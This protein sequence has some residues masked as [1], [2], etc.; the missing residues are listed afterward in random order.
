MS[1]MY[2]IIARVWTCP[3]LHTQEIFNCTLTLSSLQLKVCRFW[4]VLGALVF[5]T[6]RSRY[7]LQQFYYTHVIIAFTDGFWIQEYANWPAG[8]I[9]FERS[10]TSF[11]SLSHWK[12]SGSKDY[13]VLKIPQINRTTLKK[14]QRYYST[15]KK[16]TQETNRFG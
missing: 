5:N 3:K 8:G 15:F 1:F 14:C 16:V 4:Q 13:P 6:S 10:V 12:Q 11:P 2:K 7:R 9:G